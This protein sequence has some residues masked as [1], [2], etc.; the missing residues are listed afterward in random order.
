MRRAAR[1]DENQPAIVEALREVGAS[2]L[3][4]HSIGE[5]CPDLLV[6]FR[7]VNHLVEV[8]DSRKPP[9]ARRL[10]PDE[11][12]FADLWRGQVAVA[13]SVSEALAVLGLAPEVGDL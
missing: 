2:V 12:R 7:G 8:K 3:H 11:Q 1:I 5:G 4:L 6:G 9:S 10:T 13:E